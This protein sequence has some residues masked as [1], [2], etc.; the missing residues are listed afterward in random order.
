MTK[1]AHI[2]VLGDIHGAFSVVEKALRK[3][4][5][6][7][8]LQ[9][10]DMGFGFPHYKRWRRMLIPD[11]TGKDPEKF[12][13]RFAFIRGNH[14]SPAVCAAHPNY[15]GDFGIH[16]PT[17][18]FFFSGGEST[19]REDRHSGID[20]WPEEQLP[21]DRMVEAINLYEKVRPSVV[22]SH[23]CPSSLIPMMHSHHRTPSRTSNALQTMLDIHRPDLWCFGHHHRTWEK[24]VN[25]TFFVC[26]AI[27]QVKKFPL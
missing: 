5:G 19:D 1:P 24:K 22:I 7:P 10:G 3:H 9:V 27:N 2:A 25:G 11:P 23:E 6:V 15:L 13:T 16:E 4:P 17:G 12:Q 8:V 26:L 14:D 20:W 21:Y 18:V